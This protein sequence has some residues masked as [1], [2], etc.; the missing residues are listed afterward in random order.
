[1]NKGKKN[2]IIIIAAVLGAGL[3]IGCVFIGI[4][5]KEKR[6]LQALVGTWINEDK[7]EIVVGEN[8]D[9]GA[10]TTPFVLK[11]GFLTAYKL[12]KVSINSFDSKSDGVAWY[13]YYPGDYN[14]YKEDE[15]GPAKVDVYK[16]EITIKV[17]V[18]VQNHVEYLTLCSGKMKVKGDQ[19]IISNGANTYTFIKN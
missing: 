9:F 3:A 19:L 7:D 6:A 4:A 1:M 14:R 2:A 18:T 13:A 8:V 5:A 15:W 17:S 11:N 10:A 16:G 12:K